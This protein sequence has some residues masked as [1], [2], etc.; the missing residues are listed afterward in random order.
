M[1]KFA[2]LLLCLLA[3]L[4]VSCEEEPAAYVGVWEDSTT[5]SAAFTVVTF[6][7]GADEGTITIDYQPPNPKAD[8][9][10]VI[11]G[12][13]SSSGSTLTATITAISVGGL[14]LTPDAAIDAFLAGLTPPQGRV[15]DFTWSVSGNTLTISG[16]LI[17]A[18]TSG[19][20]STLYGQRT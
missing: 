20:F 12:T 9:D 1:K 18:L 15:N 2:L 14:P 3:L 10:V 5:L 4:F 11:T 19:V 7:L 6:D 16:D 8:S 13:L 17:S